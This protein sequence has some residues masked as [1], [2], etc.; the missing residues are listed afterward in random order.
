MNTFISTR[1]TLTS[2]GKARN[3]LKKTDMTEVTLDQI[4]ACYIRY[5]SHISKLKNAG[6]TQ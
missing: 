2:I 1:K 4:L 6:E 5:S 3:I